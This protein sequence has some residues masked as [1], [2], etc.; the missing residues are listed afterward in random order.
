MIAICFPFIST[1]STQTHTS[2]S[3]G[4]A[5]AVAASPCKRAV[6]AAAPVVALSIACVALASAALSG[7]RSS[8]GCAV[9]LCKYLLSPL[10]HLSEI[11][12]FDI[13]QNMI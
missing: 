8:H 4:G 12:L 10:R 1:V 6:L 3:S 13:S 11:L 2:S 7:A 9:R 5:V